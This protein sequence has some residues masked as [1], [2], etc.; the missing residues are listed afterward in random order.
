M[1]K[2]DIS[3]IKVGDEVEARVRA[4]VVK[5]T[6]LCGRTLFNV[7]YFDDTWLHDYEITAHQPCEREFKVGDRV[8]TAYD[9]TG[10]VVSIDGDELWV[11]GGSLK[12]MTCIAAECTH[13]D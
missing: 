10:V 8:R 5:I 4:E 3:K 13:I 9:W 11:K 6:K 7:E 1:S 12:N 2:I